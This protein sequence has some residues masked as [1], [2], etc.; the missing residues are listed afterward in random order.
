M[1]S[2]RYILLNC[3]F[4]DLYAIVKGASTYFI[5]LSYTGRA[6]KGS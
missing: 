4:S 5:G 1:Y 3:N 2:C 6:S